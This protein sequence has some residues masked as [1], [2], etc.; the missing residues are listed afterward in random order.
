MLVVYV[1][2]LNSYELAVHFFSLK[3]FRFYLDVLKR[4][5]TFLSKKNSIY[6]VGV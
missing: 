2:L 3:L 1:V 5:I 6:K 4:K